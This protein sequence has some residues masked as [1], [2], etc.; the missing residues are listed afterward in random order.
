MVPVAA[1]EDFGF[2]SPVKQIQ[3]LCELHP[4]LPTRVQSTLAVAIIERK[5]GYEEVIEAHFVLQDRNQIY[6][7]LE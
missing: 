5:P 2:A 3:L 7:L 6:R 1:P 4:L